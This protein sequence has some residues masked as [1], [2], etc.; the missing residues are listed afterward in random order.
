MSV[1][2]TAPGRRGGGTPPG[3]GIVGP[4]G[5]G[6]A[7]GRRPPGVVGV[8]GKIQP[9]RLLVRVEPEYPLLAQR[10]GIEGDVLL[11]ALLGTDGR[12]EQGRVVS[13]RALLGTSGQA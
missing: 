12:V 8:G 2:G 11:E 9:P 4:G 3:G 5:A 10:A 6:A 7:G 13:G 1:P